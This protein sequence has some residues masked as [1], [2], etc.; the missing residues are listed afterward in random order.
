MDAGVIAEDSADMALEGR[1][2][3]R[4]MRLS[5][6]ALIKDVEKDFYIFALRIR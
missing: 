1:H 2:Y 6:N 3:Y 5:F 4:N